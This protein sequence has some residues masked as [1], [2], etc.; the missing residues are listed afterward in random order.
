MK[1]GLNNL[2]APIKRHPFLFTLACL[3]SIYLLISGVIAPHVIQKKLPEWITPYPEL[4]ASVESI[5]FNPFLLRLTIDQLTLTENSSGENQTLSGFKQ[6]VVNLELSS[7][8]KQAVV[9]SE[10]SLHETYGRITKD[11]SGHFLWDR[12]LIP[13]EDEISTT[14]NKNSEASADNVFPL[15][16]EKLAI[17]QSRLD[18]E[19]FSKKTPY[20]KTVGPVDLALSNLST[21]P[22]DQG[23]Y[24]L[25]IALGQGDQAPAMTQWSGSIS[26]T[27]FQSTGRLKLNHLAINSLW[28][29][30][31][32][33]LA[34]KPLSGE[35]GLGFQ[36][37]LFT[38]PTLDLTLRE[39]WLS[40]DQI[41]LAG[42]QQDSA[43]LTLPSH[44]LSGL[45]FDLATQQVSI[46]E[47]IT[48]GL[49]ATIARLEDGSLDVNHW[50]AVAQN[51]R[52]SKTSQTIEKHAQADTEEN[53]ASKEWD[54]SVETIR[55]EQ[56]K[57]A[58]TDL[59]TQPK[60]E[61]VSDDISVEVKDFSLSENP[62]GFKLNVTNQQ[63]SSL[64]INGEFI[65][66]EQQIEMMI[67]MK[68]FP[69]ASLQ[70][71]LNQHTELKIHNLNLDLNGQ[72]SAK[73]ENATF[74]GSTQLRD[75][76]L[77]NKVHKQA[78]LAGTGLYFEG[79]KLS[80]AQKTLFINEILLDEIQY[81]VAILSRNENATTT[82][83]SGLIRTS[84]DSETPNDKEEVVQD[85]SDKSEHPWLANIG[86][87]TINQ[88][89]LQFSDR[90]LE[91]PVFF[92]IEQLNGI[93]ANLSSKNL[94]KADITLA[95]QINGYAPFNVKGQ[96]NPLSEDTYSNVEITMNDIALST[97]S[98][99]TTHF[100]NYP[101]V[102]GKLSTDLKYQLNKDDLIANNQLFIDQLELGEYTESE[103]G[104]GLPLPLAISLLQTND[105]AIN[106][107]MPIEGNLND[108]D[109]QYGQVV[110][111]TL[112][113]I[114][115]KAVTSP[116]QLIAS[117]AGSSEDL[118]HLAFAPAQ[119]KLSDTEVAKLNQLVDALQQRNSLKL[120][121]QG[122]TTLADIKALQ[123]QEWSKIVKNKGVQKDHSAL[124]YQALLAQQSGQPISD[125]QTAQ[126]IE[127][128]LIS[129]QPIPTDTLAKLAQLRAT[130]TRA[131]LLT[132]GISES[133]LFMKESLIEAQNTSASSDLNITKESIVEDNMATGI[134]LEIK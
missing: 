100:L 38:E 131:H 28:E 76:K 62:I 86:K 13:K 111:N 44:K 21:L 17:S 56:G 82:N 4:S 29:Y 19:D 132:A 25:A 69:V 127:Q 60:A 77:T 27:P 43:F 3:Y 90:G 67:D 71:Y 114:I 5:R 30:V 117:L 113:N 45:F 42:K 94:S 65:L 59:T 32:D 7:I 74:E 11:T 46:E 40:L 12:W 61:F 26:L 126:Q 98:P 87:I 93:I 130:G 47:A 16:I 79:I 50:L 81:P 22:E 107:D 2:L 121:I 84:T 64:A 18:I 14:S 36:Y 129:T 15:I 124:P 105:G 110:V 57:V 95:G 41:A 8:F 34:F 112:I 88:N 83:F 63:T 92:N 6:L 80:Q 99:Y 106:I 70:P 48:T 89:K 68:S 33:D 102:Q 125:A 73:A 118:S 1:P 54:I 104:L 39:G 134:K 120:S 97:F 91:T 109:F 78:L 9:L 20:Q 115:T 72:L 108:P 66:P 35:V 116:F 101:L 119:S 37:Q 96:I 128:K 75:I 58:F 103:A 133:R 53:I 10:F 85:A 49:S 31:Q 122:L 24:Q 52:S 23:N 51:K 55:L 123:E